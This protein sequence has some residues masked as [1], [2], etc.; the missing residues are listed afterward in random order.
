MLNAKEELK[1]IYIIIPII[2]IISIC[3]LM[4]NFSMTSN[5]LGFM[6]NHFTQYQFEDIEPETRN[7]SPTR[8]ENDVPVHFRESFPNRFSPQLLEYEDY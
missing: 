6:Y 8:S 2:F 7:S 5:T 3:L 1:K 4:Y